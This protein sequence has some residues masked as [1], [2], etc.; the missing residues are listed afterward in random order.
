[1]RM[2][3]KAK[4]VRGSGCARLFV[5]LAL[6]ATAMAQAQDA[7]PNAA[8]NVPETFD[9]NEYVVDGNTALQSLDIETA[10]YPYLGPGKSLNDVNAARDALQKI[11]QSRGY[12]SVVVE[13]PPQQVKGGVIRLQVMENTIGR[14]RVEGAKYH[15]PKEI[16]DA[17]PAL[18]EGQLPD[19]NAAQDQLTQVNRQPGRQVV[20]MLTPGSQPQT[21]DVTLKVEDASPW[22]GSIEV[23]NDHS[24]DT[25]ELRTVGSIRNDNL[26]QLGHTASFTYIVAPQD[27]NAAEV[28][29]GSYLV[30]LDADWSLLFSG[31]KSNSNANTVGGTTVLGKGNA[32]GFQ[33]IR[34]LPT[35]GTYAQSLNI[36]VTRK[37][38]DQ[39]IN[40]GT[41]ASKSPITYIPFTVSYNGQATRDKSTTNVSIGATAGMRAGGSD[42][43]E[44]DNQRY[45]AKAN[46]FYVR[47]DLTHVLRF[48]N[49]YSLSLRG[50]A[51]GATSSLVSSEQFAAGGAST[52]R[53][54]LEAEDT[55]D[56]G[57]IGSAEFRSPSIAPSVGK[58]AND[59]RFHAFVDGAHLVLSNALAQPVDAADPSRGDIRKT[60]F[61][62]LSAGLGTR[63][64]FFD[65]VTGTLEFAYPLKDGQATRAHDTRV[66]FSLRA[67]L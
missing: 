43:A 42:A 12:Q 16:R 44:F 7:Q 54:Y 40:Q 64:Q 65:F 21:M 52:V 59:W 66:H 19:F 46:F 31:Y 5:G 57:V 14:V 60:S 28:Y 2:M 48:D 27:R 61:D 17:V 37:H 53:G 13:L 67:D 29:A 38:F 8:A 22:H 30:P 36:G 32:F 4:N 56:H 35:H 26:W 47:A 51:Q 55:A 25:P 9:V 6:G 3:E 24:V 58:W 62:L 33:L 49:G 34:T 1:M 50:S 20:P 63:F 39:N 11:Y 18:A 23:N 10:V 41:A 15:S 45:R